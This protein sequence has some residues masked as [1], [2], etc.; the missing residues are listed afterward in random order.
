MVLDLILGHIAKERHF[1]LSR[2][3][4]HPKRCVMTWESSMRKSPNGAAVHTNNSRLQLWLLSPLLLLLLPSLGA[5]ILCFSSPSTHSQHRCHTRAPPDG[6]GGLRA[7]THLHPQ[8]YPEC[9]GTAG[10]MEG[11]EWEQVGPMA[12]DLRGQ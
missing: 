5:V 1:L 7:A 4:H 2:V 3:R 10:G 8:Q 9:G 6:D 11:G 12:Q